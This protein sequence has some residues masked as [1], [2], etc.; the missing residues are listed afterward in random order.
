MTQWP[1]SK[2]APQ[3]DFYLPLSRERRD[4]RHRANDDTVAEKQE[5]RFGLYPSAAAAGREQL[6]S[7][8]VHVYYGPLLTRVRPDWTEMSLVHS[9]QSKP[10][11]A[12]ESGPLIP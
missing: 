7:Y 9:V 5:G 11:R 8:Y 1:K 6:R 3:L 2:R 4:E 10:V 12:P